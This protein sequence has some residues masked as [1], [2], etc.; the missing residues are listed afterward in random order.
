MGL[1]SRLLRVAVIASLAA[2][3]CAL[4][5][6]ARSGSL[7]SARALRRR[8][9]SIALRALPAEVQ[10]AN[11]WDPGTYQEVDVEANWEALCEAY[12]SEE[13]A[14]AAAQQVR[15]SVLC[16]IYSTPNLIRDS[17]DAL[18]TVLGTDEAAV[19]MKKNPAVLTCGGDLLT[20]DP[21]DIRRFANLR[22]T[23]DKI[24]PQAL[25]ALVL[26]ISAFIL[27]KI[28]LI[29]LGLMGPVL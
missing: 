10:A 21:D 12:G 14:S 15:G 6:V 23:L 1:T 2:S 26:G 24:P 17:K 18:V 8:H 19:I 11:S 13:R 7:L 25:L 3:V 29:R 22:E 20:A 4:S 28:A 16:P 5:A 27:G 9:V